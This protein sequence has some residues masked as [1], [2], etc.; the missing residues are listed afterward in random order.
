[1]GAEH[2]ERAAV[3]VPSHRDFLAGGLGV[4]V[5]DHEGKGAEVSLYKGLRNGV[6]QRKEGV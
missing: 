6:S 3:E 1:M 4:E 5:H 2:R